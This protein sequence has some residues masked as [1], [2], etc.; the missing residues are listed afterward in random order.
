[1][2]DQNNKRKPLKKCTNINEVKNYYNVT[3][4]DYDDWCQSF[5]KLMDSE[6]GRE[7]LRLFCES[8]FSDENIKFWNTGKFEKKLN[9][10]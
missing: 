10:F 3:K 9:S 8:E 5:D 2:N 7:V 6:A 4:E 1:M